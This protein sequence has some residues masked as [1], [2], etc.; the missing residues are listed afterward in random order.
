[1][2]WLAVA[3]PLMFAVHH[4]PHLSLSG[5]VVHGTGFHSREH[6][7][8]VVKKRSGAR[9]TR[10]VVAT[11]SGAFR[12]SFAQ[13]NGPCE[14]FTITAY[15]TLGSDATLSGMKFPDCIVR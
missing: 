9:F 11:R 5:E 6:V 15:G 14:R 8:V 3:V 10:R 13:V 4:H 1:M 7:R 12:A 2:R